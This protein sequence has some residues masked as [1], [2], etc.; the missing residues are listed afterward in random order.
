LR[1]FLA[2]PFSVLSDY[3]RK[4][5]P[6]SRIYTICIRIRDEKKE[7]AAF[8]ARAVTKHLY[9]TNGGPDV[10][11]TLPGHDEMEDS[12]HACLQNIAW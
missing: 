9:Q 12:R 4:K 3:D 6:R 8:A 5:N 10:Q 2:L 7:E 11:Q 1:F